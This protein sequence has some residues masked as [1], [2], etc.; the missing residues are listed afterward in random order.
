MARF[1]ERDA[2]IRTLGQEIIAGLIA[3]AADFPAPPVSAAQLQTLVDSFVSLSDQ[4]V[5]AKAAAE[6]ATA[7]KQAAREQLIAAMRAVLRYAEDAVSHNDAKLTALGWGARAARTP[8]QAP[9]Q[10]G[11]LE[12]PYQAE[13]RITLRWAKPGDGGAVAAYRIERRQVPDGDWTIVDMSVEREATLVGQPRRTD[14]EYRVIAI[15]KAGEGPPSNTV[16][17]VL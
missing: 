1:P 3:S 6:Q 11:S 10:S 9:G 5:A 4:K 16:A 12:A 14:W 13:G 15:N 8:L 7:A 2:Q 17:A